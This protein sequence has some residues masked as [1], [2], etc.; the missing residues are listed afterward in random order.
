M[1]DED[2]YLG[3][4]TCVSKSPN[5]YLHYS[6]YLLNLSSGLNLAGWALKVYDP[7][8]RTTCNV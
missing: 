6:L 2:Q 4:G 7:S 3:S 5:L 1:D 8:S